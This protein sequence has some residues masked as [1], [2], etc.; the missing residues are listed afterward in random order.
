MNIKA[1]HLLCNYSYVLGYYTYDV[2]DLLTDGDNCIV[3]V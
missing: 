1:I 2:T 3:P